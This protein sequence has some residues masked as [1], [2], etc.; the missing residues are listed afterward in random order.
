MFDEYLLVDRKTYERWTERDRR[1]RNNVTAPSAPRAASVN[2]FQNPHVR[3][4]KRLR[5]EVE[6]L[7]RVDGV[8]E[9][10]D[11]APGE[12]DRAVETARLLLQD[13]RREFDR[14]NGRKAT[15]SSNPKRGQRVNNADSVSTP[16]VGK[17]SRARSR[18][19]LSR[20]HAPSRPPADGRRISTAIDFDD[21]VTDSPAATPSPSVKAKRRVARFR[22]KDDVTRSVGGY[23]SERDAKKMMPLLN[24]LDEAGY[25]RADGK[26][27]ERVE[28]GGGG[29]GDDNVGEGGDVFLAKRSDLR[30]YIRDVTINEPARRSNSARDIDAFGRFLKRAGIEFPIKPSTVRVS[31]RAPKRKDPRALP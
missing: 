22:T 7:T 29:G 2:P 1:E 6:G 16:P 23:V 5:R 20:S 25:V 18:S 31:D 27:V 21:S 13:Y 17:R 10:V 19:P 3:E 15:P 12:L 28:D 11:T 24:A 30:S 4:A 8:G 9:S 26:L 14:A